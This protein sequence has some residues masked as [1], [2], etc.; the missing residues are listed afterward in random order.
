M[1]SHTVSTTPIKFLKREDGLPGAQVLKLAQGPD[2]RLWA[3]TPAGLVC[4]DAMTLTVFTERHGL[5]SHGLRAL[6]FAP[7]GRLWVGS[8]TGVDI[9]QDDMALPSDSSWLHGH[10]GCIC[11]H[12]GDTWLGTAT[13]LL[14][15][16]GGKF[17]EIEDPQLRG[18]IIRTIVSSAGG[19]LF[20]AASGGKLLVGDGESWAAP[21]DLGAQDRREIRAIARGPAGHMFVGGGF[22]FAELD[23]DGSLLPGTSM[24]APGESVSALHFVNDEL[25]VA[26]NFGLDVYVHDGIEWVCDAKVIEG[27]PVSDILDDDFGNMWA[28]TEAE[29][30]AKISIFRKA[31]TPV[32]LSKPGAVF[33]V[34]EGNDG[35]L[36]VG[37]DVSTHHVNPEA[38]DTLWPLR[39]LDQK[40]VW[41]ILE[42]SDGTMY[43]AT[44]T[45]L[46][47]L[48]R[49]HAAQSIGAD[50][51]VLAR[52][53]RCLLKNGE[54]LFAGSI[55]GCVIVGPD[56]SVREVEVVGG[57]RLGYVYTLTRDTRGRVWAGTL[58]KGAW[59]QEDGVFRRFTGEGLTESG[60]TYSIEAREDGV[61]AVIQDDRICLVDL[62]GASR[63]LARRDEAVAGW[64]SCWAHDGTLWIGTTSGLVQYHSETGRKLRQIAVLLSLSEWEFTT[65]R[66]LHLMRNGDFYCGVNSG[67]VKV[68]SKE[69]E[70]LDRLPELHV[71]KIAWLN[72]SPTVVDGGYVVE[73]G[74]WTLT[75]SVFAAWYLDENDLL[76]RYRL[77]GFDENWSELGRSDSINFSSLPPGQYLLQAQAFSPLV[78]FGPVLQVMDLTVRAPLWAKQWVLAPMRLFNA[79][80]RLNAALFRNRDLHE[81][82]RLLEQEVRERLADLQQAK[83][84]LE[85]LNAE[86]ESEV[87]TDALTGIS[88]RRHFDR[89][90]HEALVEAKVSKDVLSLIMVDIDF[91]KGY[92]DCYGHTK[93]D[94]ILGYVARNMNSSL[95]RPSDKVARYGGEEF[96]VIAPRTD[97]A[98]IKL[99]AER[100]RQGVRNLSIPH[101]K[102]EKYEVITISIGATTVDFGGKQSGVAMTPERLIR[103]ADEA[104]Y[105]AKEG[106][107]NCWVF[108]APGQVPGL[109]GYI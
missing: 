84:R 25:W 9:F 61:L 103:E 24:Y 71:G 49:R 88:N 107:R 44:A 1:K 8:D 27:E 37:G 65:S 10:V 59:L 75:A 16:D 38:G 90:L 3:A 70:S 5:H 82:N 58:G 2:G 95:Y 45:G 19:K 21:L 68:S 105:A 79:F 55:G 31:I 101:A 72:T 7:D 52:H 33:V 42:E 51:P 23:S 6:S 83:K 93:G 100:L 73:Q 81:R 12:A 89:L 35:R 57:E 40:Q 39:A 11:H 53:I 13:G 32:Q 4:Y 20:V 63:V 43:A 96:A 60:N 22:G 15:Y 64:C 36:L 86:L 69:I 91:F 104:L 92:N 29:G 99:L 26:G 47:H 54:D 98:G 66:S 46:I 34:A 17:G 14:R 76:I 18:H 94:D 97:E 80:R 56:K 41:D 48:D 74:R 85:S 102:S 62:D 78:G 108:K 87:I 30:I 50:H 67:L 106:G 109:P 77:L 28:A